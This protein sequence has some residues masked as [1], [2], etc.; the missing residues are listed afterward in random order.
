MYSTPSSTGSAH[1]RIDL[2]QALTPLAHFLAVHTASDRVRIERCERLSGGAIQENWLLTAT[3][4]RA[5]QRLERRWVLRTDSPSSVAVSM[6]REQ[7]FAVLSAVHQAGVKVPEPLWLCRDPALIGRDFFVMQALSGSASGYRLSTDPSLEPRR[8]E[9]C[10]ELG[11]SLAA[12]HRITPEHPALGFLPAA[13][14]DHAQACIDQYRQYLDAL[15]G[16]HPVIEWGLRWC[17]VNRPE[18]VPARLIHRDYRTGNYMVDGGQLTGVLDWE[19]AGW[20]DPREDLGWFTAR[21]WRFGRPD[22]QAG[23]VGELD[24]FLDGYQALAGWRPDADELRYWQLMAHLRW[25]V[26]A[27]QQAQRHL[28]GQQRSLELALTGRMVPELEH[29]ILNLS[30]GVR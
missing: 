1:P 15:P 7:E 19:F 3:L 9:L 27:L 29:E 8:G 30:G 16:S 25:A 12:L 22:R 5:E 4:E 21:C 6:S 26:V 2:P 20:G 13:Q 14:A 28:T 17:E 18:P 11:R 23:G 24:D 10:R